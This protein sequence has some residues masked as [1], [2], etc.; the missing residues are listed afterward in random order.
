MAETKQLEEL[1]A[2]EPV[3]RL[4][5]RGITAAIGA[6]HLA[7]GF[8]IRNF[9]QVFGL[10]LRQGE[11]GSIELLPEIGLILMLTGAVCLFLAAYPIRYR[12]L[13]IFVVL[14]WLT[15]AML[16]LTGI[17]AEHPTKQLYFHLIMN[18]GIST[19]LALWILWKAQ[20]ASKHL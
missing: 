12:V 4:S 5:H 14:V 10:W 13:Y 20:I 1:E 15:I 16:F 7:W 11:E 6:W 19:M 18:Y 17:F 3:F 2:R 9:S 8:F